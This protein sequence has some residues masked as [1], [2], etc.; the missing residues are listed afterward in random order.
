MKLR[1]IRFNQNQL[2]VPRR[3]LNLKPGAKK[4]TLYEKDQLK[5]IRI[6]VS[7]QSQDLCQ[8][9]LGSIKINLDKSRSI[10][11]IYNCKHN[12]FLVIGLIKINYVDQ[13]LPIKIN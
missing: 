12:V 3:D 11:P 1:S 2:S 7:L 5:S 6:K 4:E 13:L 10:N 8:D 9:K